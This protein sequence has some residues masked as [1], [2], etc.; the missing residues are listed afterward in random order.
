LAYSFNSTA[1]D[2][3]SAMCPGVDAATDSD[4]LY[5]KFLLNG[6][7]YN[8]PP[9]VY[10]QTLFQQPQRLRFINSGG[11]TNFLIVFP[12]SVQL[13]ATDGEY[14]VP[15]EGSQF[16]ISVA[17]RLDFLIQVPS[18]WSSDYFTV[19]GYTENSVQSVPTVIIFSQT[20]LSSAQAS[21]I[22][23]SIANTPF[24]AGM[25]SNSL[26]SA[27]KAFQPLSQ[28]PVTTVF[29][30]D[31]TGDNG[32]RGINGRSYRLPPTA[33]LPYVPNEYPLL[34]NYGDR[35]QITFQN[36]NPD[37]H[38]MHMHGH[39]FQIVNINGAPV[40]GPMRDVAFVPGGCNNVT[41]EFEANNPG[42]W[43]LH[44]HLEF[45]SAAGMLTSVE[46]EN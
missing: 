18:S 28:A 41:I 30:L 31:L 19:I 11:M 43:A 2:D 24:V 26:D 25:M 17:Q 9:V 20:S 34:V 37:G 33:P 42:I 40:N 29:Q 5:Q 23:T 38:P 12:F 7:T 32:F 27:V 35:V 10:N 46:Y 39:V 6:N 1:G 4:V 45:H 13:I 44:C 15:Y 14:V 36:Y 8:S 21:S 16:W 3:G 22:G